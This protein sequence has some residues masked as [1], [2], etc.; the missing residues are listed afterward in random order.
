VIFLITVFYGHYLNVEGVTGLLML[1][2]LI[3]ILLLAAVGQTVEKAQELDNQQ[4]INVEAE[5]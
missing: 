1:C 2:G 3:A 5:E 4:T